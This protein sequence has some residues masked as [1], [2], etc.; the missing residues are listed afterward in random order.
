MLGT[1]WKG[2]KRG[3]VAN[4]IAIVGLPECREINGFHAKGLL[5][6]KDCNEGYPLTH[7]SQEVPEVV[8]CI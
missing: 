5:T 8:S 7:L 2:G 6:W 3:S 4:S 1:L